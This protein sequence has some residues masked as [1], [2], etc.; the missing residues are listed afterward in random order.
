MGGGDVDDEYGDAGFT[1]RAEVLAAQYG[2]PAPR[3]S[4]QGYSSG[5]E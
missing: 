2:S 3:R 1:D 5:Q 4:S